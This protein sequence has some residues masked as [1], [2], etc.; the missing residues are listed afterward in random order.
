M[1]SMDI[2][3]REIEDLL[4]VARARTDW[5]ATLYMQGLQINILQGVT[6]CTTLRLMAA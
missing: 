6:Q 5:C 1:S 4:T 2:M 3:I